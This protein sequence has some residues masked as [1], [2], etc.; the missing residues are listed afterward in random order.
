MDRRPEPVVLVGHS[1][2]GSVITGAADQRP[3][4]ASALVYLDAFVPEDGDSAWSMTNDEQREWYANDSGET[5][6]AVKPLPFFDDRARPHPLGTLM[7]RAKLT[8]AWKAVPRKRYV[9][10]AAAE[11]LKHSPFVGVT[12]RLR[13]DP[14]WTVTE[15][16]SG[17]NL[18]AGGPETLVRILLEYA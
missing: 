9:A 5:G 4:Q 7:Q 16:D 15:L 11:W 14:D 3:E 17:H 6:L 2:A 12:A 1:Y 18:L 13:D 10:A 8:G